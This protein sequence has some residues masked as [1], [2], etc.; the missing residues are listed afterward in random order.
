MNCP[1]FLGSY[2]DFRD[3]LI[4]DPHVR[5]QMRQHLLSCVSCARYDASVRHGIRAVGQVDVSPDFR[6]RLRQRIAATAGRPVA[7]AGPRATSVAAG[8]MVAVAVC[9]L[10]Y[11]RAIDT[12]PD[13]AVVP[14]EAPPEVVPVAPPE[15]QGASGAY[16]DSLVDTLGLPRAVA[17]ARRPVVIVNSGIPFV[18]FTDMAA[19][20]SFSSTSSVQTNVSLDHP[21]NL[22]R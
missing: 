16:E 20:S 10:V 18:V 7:P 14:A 21:P 15:T 19:A 1:D 8:L 11:E 22:P 4:G 12:P 6:D 9:L 13:F 17:A 5:Q 3:G 2:S